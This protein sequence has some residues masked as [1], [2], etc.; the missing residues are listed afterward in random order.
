MH[1]FFEPHLFRKSIIWFVF[2]NVFENYS[3][4]KNA[5]KV[6]RDIHNYM[7]QNLLHINMG[8]SVHMYFRPN[9]NAYKR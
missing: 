5:N 8:K 3:I 9:L 4:A 1:P 6:L 7:L 2:E